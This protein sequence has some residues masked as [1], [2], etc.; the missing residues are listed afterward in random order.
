MPVSVVP[1]PTTAGTPSARSSATTSS[2]SSAPE[3]MRTKRRRAE[4]T[5]P[6]GPRRSSNARM[7]VNDAV[8]KLSRSAR[9]AAS[10]ASTS[11][12]GSASTLPPFMIGSNSA[13]RW[14]LARWIG[15]TSPDVS[16][17]PSAKI[18]PIA[19][20][21]AATDA[22]PYGTSF[23]RSVVPDVTHRYAQRGSW[24]GG[25]PS[26]VRPASAS[27]KPNAPAASPSDANSIRATPR[28]SAGHSE[29]GLD[30]AGNQH[31]PHARSREE[32]MACVGGHRRRDERERRCGRGGGEQRARDRAIAHQRRHDVAARDPPRAEAIAHVR[33]PLG[34]LA[35]AQRRAA[36][37]EQE[38]RARV[39]RRV[40]EQPRLDVVGQ[41]FPLPRDD[42]VHA[43]RAARY[44]R[45]P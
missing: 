9:I 3:A 38:R 16:A 20:V 45:D 34:Q 39:A 29:D 24:R 41:N 6:C 26:S 42:S 10:A 12:S 1:S 35:V 5:R 15:V 43:A 28:A 2:G 7:I 25:A 18:S 19:R 8:K 44:H 22:C 17:G 4:R 30:V 32:L 36:R 23:G 13:V 31:G 37:S 33:D 27:D 14:P 11:A 40:L 21:I